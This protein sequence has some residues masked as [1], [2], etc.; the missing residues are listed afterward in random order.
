MS[1]G[2]A[3]I[4]DDF[5]VAYQEERWK[6][7]IKVLDDVMPLW[8]RH[9]ARLDLTMARGWCNTAAVDGVKLYWNPEF[10]ASLSDRELLFL[11]TH[12]VFHIANGHI[13]RGARYLKGLVGR[14]LREVLRRLNRA[15]DFTIHQILVPLI[16]KKAYRKMKFP[17]GK[18][19]G[20]YDKRFYNMSMEL[21]YDFLLNNPNDK[22]NGKK[23]KFDI[24]I[25]R[26][27]GNPEDAPEGASVDEDGNW[28]LVVNGDGDPIEVPQEVKDS[29]TA[30]EPV[31]PKKVQ[32]DIKRDL[33]TFE[34]SGTGEI[35]RAHV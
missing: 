33:Q 7:A 20:L 26:G 16:R 19:R 22:A 8:H 10:T 15:A 11:L 24:H 1:V 9:A 12:E 34:N 30:P 3:I 17:T 29:G 13:W 35:G 18:N 31:S 4:L 25:F 5:G 28:V 23:Q 27:A 2:G 14:E 32:V 21:I 6:D